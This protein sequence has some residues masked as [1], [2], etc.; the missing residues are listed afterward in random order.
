MRV[1]TKRIER[2]RA[3][4][5]RRGRRAQEAH[6]LV[7]MYHRVATPTAD[8]WQLAVAPE[9]FDEQLRALRESF[10]LVPLRE[11]RERLRSGRDSRPVAAVTFDDGYLD[12][13][14]VAKPLLERHAVPATVFVIT[15]FV[16]RREGF[17]WDRLAHAVLG[18]APL[19]SRLEIPGDPDAFRFAGELL[20]NPG[21]AGRRARRHMHDRLWAWLCD[22]PDAAKLRALEF[23]ERWSGRAPAQDPGGRPMNAYELRELV[24][25]GL[26]DVGAHTVTHPRLSRLPREAQA[27]EI[28]QSRR[29]C[30]AILDRDPSVFSYPN[31]DY[32]P[33]S[34]ELVRQAGFALACDSR[35]DLAWAGDDAHRIPR[36]S[37]KEETGDALSRR[38]RW[39]WLA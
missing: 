24:S 39:G 35:A 25:G 2:A 32:A 31:G 14:T 23:L 21:A 34:V 12:N 7:L 20:A 1:L 26:V 29:D 19:P 27:A 10:D 11:L 16:G 37:V 33:E 13:L 17:W 38:L 4:T 36:I 9:T 18:D 22:Q 15:G 8:P 28:E 5:R 30:R 3:W 6:G